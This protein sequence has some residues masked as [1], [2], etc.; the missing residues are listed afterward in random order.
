M[1]M[2]HGWIAHT[3]TK[4]CP[5]SSISLAYG[6]LLPVSQWII[7]PHYVGLPIRE[8]G[9]REIPCP[10]NTGKITR[11]M[12]VESVIDTGVLP[13]S[14]MILSLCKFEDIRNS[15]FDR[16]KT[17]ITMS[18]HRQGHAQATYKGH[19]VTLTHAGNTYE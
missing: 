6:N 19:T 16:K 1:H 12:R 8:M 2:L 14:L 10:K 4:R 3:R 18:D 5:I 15:T 13:F 9:K 7:L 11:P 17:K